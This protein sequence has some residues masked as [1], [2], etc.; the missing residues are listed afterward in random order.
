MNPNETCCF[1]GNRPH[2]LPWGGDESNPDCRRFIADL[3]NE[4]TRLVGLGFKRFICGMA[5]GTDT[6]F[7]E[8]VLRLKSEFPAII[9]EA[10]VPCPEQPDRWPDKDR[11]RYRNLL[12]QCDTVTVL[13]S[14]YTTD[15]MMRRNRYMVDR[16]ALVITFSRAKR[17]GT[18][19][20]VRY[21]EQQ[22]K[23]II[24]L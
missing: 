3:Q 23:A 1:T 16:S 14:R 24:K 13:S 2:K 4:L 12:E 11:I 19:A 20:T 8:T 7:A 17:G 18:T 5:L 6:L 21:A 22:G 10:A 15:C 9:L